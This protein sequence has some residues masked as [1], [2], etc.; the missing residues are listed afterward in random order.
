MHQLNKTLSTDLEV[1]SDTFDPVSRIDPKILQALSK[2]VQRSGENLE[3]NLFFNHHATDLNKLCY[4]DW[5]KNK[6]KSYSGFALAHNVAFEIG[7]NA[8]HS[9]LLA[10]S[11]NKNLKLIAIDIAEHKYTARCYQILKEVFGSRLELFSANSLTLP[12]I[13]PFIP[14]N[15]TLFHIDGGHHPMIAAT[16]MANIM[17][18]AKE[19][20]IIVF[21]DTT[22]GA[23]RS[24]VN[25]YM[26]S[27]KVSLIFDP[28]GPF[29]YR[30][31][32]ALR[33]N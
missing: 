17:S 29:E 16:D 20:S 28:L 13:K 8:G 10:L 22:L 1:Y 14:E 18:F 11:I 7:F 5:A 23:L 4:D 32:M 21:D 3:G 27:G 12:V 25:F 9:A 26:A 30:S 31:H 19:G 33:V 2:E 6:R 15:T 24:I